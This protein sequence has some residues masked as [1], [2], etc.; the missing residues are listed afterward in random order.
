MCVLSLSHVRFFAAL[1]IVATWLL[2]PSNFSDKNAGAGCHFLLQGIF[3]T[4]GLNCIS[5]VSKQV[6]SF[7]TVAPGKPIYAYI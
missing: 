1:W 6:D 7:T 4:Q 2:C 5:F 3:P